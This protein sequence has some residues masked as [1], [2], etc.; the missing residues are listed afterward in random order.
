[1]TAAPIVREANYVDGRWVPPAAGRSLDVENPYTE[2][3]AGRAP[4]SDATDVAAAVAAADRAFDTWSA[5]PG[6][7]RA[8]HLR[9]LH[10]AVAD[11]VEDLAATWTAE[12]GIPLTAARAATAG[13]PLTV[14]AQMADL[15]ESAEADQT[16]GRTIVSRV[17]IG[18]VGAITPWNYPL[19]QL[20][21][22][23][24][25]ALAAGCTVVAKP[26]EIAPLCAYAFADIVDSVGLPP[27]VF[28]LV[29]GDG[30][31]VGEAIA[32]DPR[33][34]AV[35][36]TGSTATGRR[37]MTLAAGNLARVCL[38]LG[39]KSASL[40]L[41]DEVLE[42]AVR[43][44]VASCLRNGGQTCTALTRL[45]VPR[46]LAD[47]AVAVAA[48]EMG[49]VVAGDP[50]DERTTLG[51]LVSAR[52]RARVLDFVAGADADPVYRGT[53]PD[54]SGHFVA[55]TL[56][57]RVDPGSPLAQEE[58]FG[59]VLAVLEVADEDEAVRVANGTPYGLAAAVWHGDH[60]HALAVARRMVAGSV[61]VN[62]GAF[63]ATAPYGGLRH[64][65]LG[66][67]LGQAGIDEFLEARAIFRA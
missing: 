65:G 64:S 29:G 20:A 9:A 39:G 62:G 50:T 22:K 21:I 42:Q 58:I 5:T 7:E 11:R 26:S 2:G 63:D 43:A 34:R 41:D 48:D 25:T 4:L 6:P 13:L 8:G 61:T 40:V 10:R 49:R 28:N 27:G 66:R 52:Q 45:V 55:P 46:R 24:A 53:V 56:F 14:L 67:E 33:V 57:R 30:P 1:M 15:A 54:G 12:V 3:V 37:V 44:T 23:T 47:R 35:S 38:E 16:S 32:G 19:S 31:A 18:V 51:P 17:P 60:E 36:F 59:P